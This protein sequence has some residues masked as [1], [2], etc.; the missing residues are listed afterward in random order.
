MTGKEHGNG[1]LWP[2]QVRPY[3]TLHHTTSQPPAAPGTSTV[4]TDSTLA[5]PSSITTA[6]AS[7]IQKPSPS[8]SLTLYVGVSLE[9]YHCHCIID[10]KTKSLCISNTVHFH[11]HYI[12]IL[13][14]TPAD[15]MVHSLDTISNAIINAPSTT[16]NI[17]LHPISTLCD[18]FNRWEEPCT[19][20][21]ATPPHFHTAALWQ[22]STPLQQPLPTSTRQTSKPSA[23]PIH[24][25]PIPPA[26]LP[27]KPPDSPGGHSTSPKVTSPIMQ[28]TVKFT[29][30]ATPRVE[31]PTSIAH[32]TCS[33]TTADP[34]FLLATPLSHTPISSRTRSHSAQSVT[35]A[36]ASSRRYPSAL[37]THWASLACTINRAASVFDEN[38]G[39]FLEWRQLWT[40]LTLSATWNTSYANKLGG[41]CQGIGTGPNDGKCVKSTNTLFSILYDK[42][43]AKRRRE[44]TYSKVI[45]KVQPEKGDKS[46]CT[47]ITIGGNNIAYPGDVGTPTGSIELVKL[48]INSVLSQQK[49]LLATMDLKNFYLNT[50]LDRPE[51]ICI[52]LADIPKNSLMCTSS[53]SLLMTPGSISKCAMACTV[54]PKQASLLTTSSETAY[55]NSTTMRQPPPPVFG[56]T[57]GAP[58]CLQSLLTTLPFNT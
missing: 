18:L 31:A 38:T 19:I 55:P 24:R 51:Y 33:H 2:S 7:S 37:I 15:T 39:N 49:A 32:W 46:D 43:P 53:T 23:S 40:H 26:P 6:I 48:L 44:I 25:P 1:W 58:S 17:Q 41:L 8:A 29:L 42:I 4:L 3:I 30:A 35:R 20:T 45:Y 13:T 50:P 11:H 5:S 52:K 9:H 28:L 36:H 16:S 54:S 14:V 34:I 22:T 47:C 57:S 12:T 21:T 56:I 27:Q 10:S